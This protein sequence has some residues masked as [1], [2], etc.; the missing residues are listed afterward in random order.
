MKLPRTSE[1]PRGPVSIDVNSVINQAYQLPGIIDPDE[2]AG[3]SDASAALLKLNQAISQLNTEQLIPWARK[4]VT[5]SGLAPALSYSMGTQEQPSDPLPDIA[6]SRPLFVNRLLYFPNANTM[7]LNVQQVDLPDLLYRRKSITASGTPMYFAVDGAYPYTNVNFDIRP[8]AGSQFSI[9]YNEP[10]P[11]CVLGGTMQAPPEYEDLMI[12]ALARKLAVLKQMPSDTL[13]MIETLYRE[14]VMRVT[15][16]N[17]R[18][19]IPLLDDLAGY[20]NWRTNTI[21]TGNASR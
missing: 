11:R 15:Q 8:Q 20:S 12:C 5:V 16:A 1:N 4:T 7:P 10:V 3:G 6:A 14:S 2:T 21:L 17:S 19:Q 18:L 13:A 9:T